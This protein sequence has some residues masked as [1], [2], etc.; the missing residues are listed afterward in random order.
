MAYVDGK[1]GT[2]SWTSGSYTLSAKW[3]EHYDK[4]LNRS[5][6]WIRELTLYSPTVDAYYL[7][8][9]VKINGTTV[10]TASSLAGGYYADCRSA[11]TYKVIN[12]TTDYVYINHNS[13]GKKSINITLSG[14][15]FS[16]LNMIGLYT[17]RDLEFSGSKSIALTN[18]PRASS[19]TTAS[20]VTLGNKC[21]IKWTPNSTSFTY[22]IKFSLGS[23]SYTTGT[24]S[25]KTT[26]A[27][28]YTGYTIPEKVA[29][30][31][32]SS[33]TG[34][35]KATLY[36]YSGSTSI[37]STTKNFTVT[38]PTTIK[39]TLDGTSVSVTLDNSS[40]S[41][42]KDWGIYVAG[43]SKAMITANAKFDMESY[44]AGMNFVISGGYSVTKSGTKNTDGTYSLSYTGAALTAGTKSFTVQAKDTRGRTSSSKTISDI[45]VHG[46][47]APEITS[48][49]IS[50][51][52]EDSTKMVVTSSWTY[53]S[54]DN[55][56]KINVILHYK[57]K[58]S[59]TWSSIVIATNLAS[60]NLNKTIDN[61]SFSDTSSFNFYIEIEDSIGN[62]KQSPQSF[63]PTA[64]VL[65]NYRGNKY[66]IGLGI[67]KVAEDNRLEV[68][69]DSV[70]FG[71]VY[72]SDSKGETMATLEDYIKSVV[73]K[74]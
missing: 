57:Q 73:E 1:S 58:S 10:I 70:F 60:T 38:V 65:L 36:T 14:N 16:V 53:S 47:S 31:I 24:I 19:I 48:F 23:F 46:Y 22:K 5:R 69:L 11:G 42:I 74:M 32:T 71:Q 21:S 34:T 64:Q 59:P 63:V 44:G 9:V 41:V 35:M 43:Y 15:S 30:N 25:P 67:G 40:N 2:V 52:N 66:G 33:A 28:T 20:N 37:G 51:D 72:I 68:G 17:G 45:V 12:T 13:D 7:D 54:V 27:Y 50:R 29:S 18:I 49:S 4:D 3:F 61:I 39:P 6:V 62:S 56:N 55:N 26:S 8:G